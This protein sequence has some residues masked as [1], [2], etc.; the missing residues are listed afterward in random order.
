MKKFSIII[1]ILL[2]FFLIYFV[3]LA[4]KIYSQFEY[5]PVSALVV[6][7][8]DETDP[9]ENE[10]TLNMRVGDEYFI[11]IGVEPE[12]ASNPMYKR[13][14]KCND[15]DDI[16]NGKVIT[17]SPQNLITANKVGNATITISSF[18]NT[19]ISTT[20]KIEVVD[21][22]FR[23]FIVPESITLEEGESQQLTVTFDPIGIPVE[24]KEVSFRLGDEEGSDPTAISI[25]PNG[26]I[27]AKHEGTVKIYVKSVMRE[28]EKV[29]QVTVTKKESIPDACFN[30]EYTE[31]YDYRLFVG[32]DEAI[33]HLRD[34]VIINNPSAISISNIKFGV[35][36]GQPTMEQ[37]DTTTKEFKNQGILEFKQ[38]TGIIEIGIYNKFVTGKPLDTVKIKY[39]K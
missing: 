25:D 7:G 35:V 34:Y 32:A 1:L 39:F 14:V 15:G 36:S 9:F 27:T 5:I 11:N 38:S 17:L 21:D 29:V 13:V 6:T 37:V 12:N 23:D 28:E 26:L 19:D 24:Q 31:G 10:H 2:P 20:L 18:D 22:I 30:M 16:D 8:E 4:G 3:S 33:V